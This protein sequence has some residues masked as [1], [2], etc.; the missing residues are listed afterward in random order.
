M[1]SKAFDDVYAVLEKHKFSKEYVRANVL[2]DWWEDEIAENAIGKT[3]GLY[4]VAR[5]LCFDL[6]ALRAEIEEYNKIEE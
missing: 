3:E 2:P 6:A 4:F 1:S 5:K